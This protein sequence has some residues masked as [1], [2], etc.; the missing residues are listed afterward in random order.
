[1]KR[2]FMTKARSRWS[3]AVPEPGL[4]AYLLAWWR[5]LVSVPA[6]GVV[7]VLVIALGVWSEAGSAGI[8]N[9]KSVAGIGIGLVAATSSWF[10]LY[11]Q[12]KQTAG[13]ALGLSTRDAR[14][15][16]VGSPA[17]LQASVDRIRAH[18]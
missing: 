1:M 15:L 7:A 2:S 14:K 6:V 11:H 16:D 13:R 12:V 3:S 5:L 17:L 10:V 18:R 4:D 8:P 9:L